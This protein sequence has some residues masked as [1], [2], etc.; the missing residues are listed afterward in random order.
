MLVADCRR[1]GVGRGAAGTPSRRLLMP[2]PRPFSPLLLLVE[3]GP[4]LNSGPTTWMPPER[5]AP[6]DPYKGGRRE[7]AGGAP[8]ADRPEPAAAR[9]DDRGGSRKIFAPLSPFVAGGS[10][11]SSCERRGGHPRT[12]VVQ[13]T[14]IK[15]GSVVVSPV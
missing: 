7:R 2:L 13:F 4:Y 3:G 11:A 12:F 1:E 14:S 5:M 8:L 9:H 6:G 15:V 10:L